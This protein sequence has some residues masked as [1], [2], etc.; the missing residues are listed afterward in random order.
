MD[1]GGEGSREALLVS[2]D[3]RTTALA[4]ISI[5]ARYVARLSFFLRAH[6]FIHPLHMGN[7]SI[8]IPAIFYNRFWGRVVK[9]GEPLVLNRCPYT[10]VNRRSTRYAM[11]SRH[12]ISSRCCCCNRRSIF[13]RQANNEYSAGL[14]CTCAAVVRSWE[15]GA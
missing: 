14:G 10:R 15:F 5:S 6:G 13:A 2:A 12:A 1:R 8:P 11:L 9:A 3:V 4:M 7:F